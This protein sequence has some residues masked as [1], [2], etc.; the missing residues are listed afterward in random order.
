[1]C[2][3]FLLTHLMRGATSNGTGC[4]CSLRFLL[5]HLMRGATRKSRR[6]GIVKMISTHAP[7]ARCDD[8]QLYHAFAYARFLLTHL[9]RGA[10]TWY[11]VYVNSN[12][13]LLTHL[14]RGATYVCAVQFLVL[15]FLLTHLMRG[16]TPLTQT[17]YSSIV[18]STH[19]P[20]ARCDRRR[21]NRTWKRRYFYS[22]TSCEVRP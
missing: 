12:E 4:V 19:A 6:G 7:H 9:M 1:M 15:R 2:F 3:E 20:H 21:D 13:F 22:R 17:G 5:T 14:M 11:T 18:I 16:A 10:T 8:S